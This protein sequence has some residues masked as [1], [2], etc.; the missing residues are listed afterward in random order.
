[1]TPLQIGI[2]G[3][4][5]YSGGELLRLLDGHPEVQVSQVSSQRMQGKPVSL[6]HP[7]LR[8]RSGLRFVPIEALQPCDLL[9]SCLPHRHSARHFPVLRR[10]A[11]RIIDLSADFRLQ[12]AQNY[13][14][15]YGEPHP[16][17]EFLSDFVYGIVEIN[18]QRL[19]K[20]RYVSGA[21]CN[22]TAVTLALLPLARAGLLSGRTVICDV[23]AGTSQGGAGHS[24]GSHH[25]ARSGS[26]RS[27]KSI[28][29][30]HSAE[31]RNNLGCSDIFMSA[32]SMD[33]V[34]GV[35]ATCHLPLPQGLDEKAVWRLYR[36]AYAEEPFVRIVKEKGGIFRAPDP[37]ILAGTNYCDIG[38]DLDE[39]E[40]RL[41]VTAAL[42]NL[43]K[44][45]A[46]QAVQAM[47]LML[48][49]PER[50]ALE[51]IGLYP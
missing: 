35:L 25:P 14:Y 28:G 37:K 31:I 6:A 45:A 12:D 48:G 40:G 30:R 21:G 22:A 32:T 42:D 46:G 44:G 20:A 34:R 29:H 18:R 9:F 47:N 1:M 5:G 10:L 23:K 50:M 26:L 33:L 27:Y 38:F 17:P 51:F 36:Q 24:A 4:S 39:R 2:V 8:G 3:A 16:C 19:T 49:Y 43:V 7:N 15:W 13:E 11:P 41:V